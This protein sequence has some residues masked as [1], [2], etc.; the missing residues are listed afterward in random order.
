MSRRSRAVVFRPGSR[1]GYETVASPGSQAAIPG[2]VYAAFEKWARQKA[3]SAVECYASALNHRLTRRPRQF[4]SAFPDVDGPFRGGGAF[5][6]DTA[7]KSAGGHRLLV[8]NSPFCPEAL[9]GLAPTLREVME[10]DAGTTAI[11]VVPGAAGR[12]GAD[13]AHL[14]ALRALGPLAEESLDPQSHVYER[15]E[16]H[17]PRAPPGSAPELHTALFVFS[18]RPTLDAVKAKVLSTALASTWAEAAEAAGTARRHLKAQVTA[19]RMSRVQPASRSAASQTRLKAPA[20][21]KPESR[22]F[23]TS[24]GPREMLR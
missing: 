14:A 21:M 7:P 13:S 4:C 19:R 1:A 5:S 23:S 16:A 9:A 10:A 15:G 18:S 17:R 20:S 24:G 12:L 8:A 22:T 6:M 3:G 11:V 2:Q